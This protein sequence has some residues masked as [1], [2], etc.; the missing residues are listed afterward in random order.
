VS[1]ANFSRSVA[2]LDT[3]SL[4]TPIKRV[5]NFFAPALEW[6]HAPAHLIAG[7]AASR[8]ATGA[9]AC[10]DQPISQDQSGD[11]KNDVPSFA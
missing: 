4:G 5:P 11:V 1:A 2:G 3:A 10:E 9:V 6:R 8:D 7:R